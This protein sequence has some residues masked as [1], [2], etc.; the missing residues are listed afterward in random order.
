MAENLNIG[1]Y[2]ASVNT[3]NSHSDVYNNGTIEKYCLVN[4]TFHCD[5]RGGL[6]DWNEM[7]GYTTTPGVQG[8]CPPTGGWHLPTDA[9]W[10]TLTNY[11]GGEVG[12]GGKLKV[13]GLSHWSAP[14]A[15][16]D[17]SSGFTAIQAYGR[18]GEGDFG[19]LPMT[20]FWSS[21]DSSN[22]AFGRIIEAWS[23]DVWRVNFYP[24]MSGYSV[25]CV[26]N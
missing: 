16:A 9:E 17:N 1:T 24:K 13:P 11:L 10:T 22:C 7:M 2:V 12:A 8:I 25:R 6:Y 19:T 14:N 18:G 15:G 20:S 5:L 23:A 21:T 26:K 3:W 4:Y